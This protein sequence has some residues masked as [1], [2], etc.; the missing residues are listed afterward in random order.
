V[1]LIVVAVSIALGALS[2]RFIE[3]P[4]RRAGGLLRRHSVLSAAA[5]AMLAVLGGGGY[6]ID[7]RQGFP[8]RFPAKVRELL[9]YKDYVVNMQA[10]WRAGQCFL[11]NPQ[12]WDN[13]DKAA[14]LHPAHPSV[15]LWGDSH[16]A[17]LY[18]PLA[19]LFLRHGMELSQA[20]AAGCAPILGYAIAA[21]PNCRAFNEKVFEWVSQ[22]RPDKIVL[23][24]VWPLKPKEVEKFYRTVDDLTSLGIFAIVETPM[25]V[26]PV[27]DILAKRLL[28][29]GG[30]TR[31]EDTDNGAALNCDLL[32]APHFAGRTDII[33]LS[34]KQAFC[35]NSTCPLAGDDG[36]PLQADG[37]HF[38]AP[39][40]ALLVHRLFGVPSVERKIFGSTP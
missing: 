33:Y 32:F 24:A 2:Y 15:L 1:N 11:G 26:E 34:P 6:F 38:T 21:H 22:T 29:D 4:F 17:H 20:N 40:A 10:S 31:Y 37:D 8:S 3:T 36:M 18:Q 14:C 35:G 9:A 30:G 19:E 16:A 7:A 27:P 12:T 28:R 25:H 5:L 13:L 23:S 39:G